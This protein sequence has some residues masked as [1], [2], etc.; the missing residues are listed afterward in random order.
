M[1]KFQVL[2]CLLFTLTLFSGCGDMGGGPEHLD[3]SKD[4]VEVRAGSFG[5][6][7]P[8]YMKPDTS[9]RGGASLKYAA[10]GKPVFVGVSQEPKDT[11]LRL[12]LSMDRMKDGDRLSTKVH[13][14]NAKGMQETQTGHV[15]VKGTDLLI[16]GLEATESE[17]AF[18][19]IGGSEIVYFLTCIVGKESVYT[20]TCWT[21]AADR[22]QYAET[23][24]QI[25]HSFKE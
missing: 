22:N 9:L 14:I 4:F 12:L 25:A 6:M 5:I 13:D 2:L 10:E 18:R 1:R 17:F 21:S 20:I 3:L 15:A 8:K 11:L 19:E 16:N 24:Q 23:M 7:L